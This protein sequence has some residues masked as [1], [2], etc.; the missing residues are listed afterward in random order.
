MTNTFDVL[1]EIN[2]ISI[3]NKN[4]SVVYTEIELGKSLFGNN[5]ILLAVV[6]VRCWVERLVIL[7]D[8]NG[9]Y[10]ST[11]AFIIIPN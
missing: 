7:S 10:D 9:L 8:I 3:V 11:P 6:A 4:Y 5:D 1:L 2:V